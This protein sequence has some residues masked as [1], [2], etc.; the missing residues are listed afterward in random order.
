MGFKAQGLKVPRFSTNGTETVAIG[1]VAVVRHVTLFLSDSGKVPAV[2]RTGLPLLENNRRAL[3]I[4]I[5]F[6]HIL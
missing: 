6:G 2:C 3:V 1:A 4:G 5:G